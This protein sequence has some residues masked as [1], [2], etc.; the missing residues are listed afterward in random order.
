MDNKTNF[1]L[2]A[3]FA[4]NMAWALV[5]RLAAWKLGYSELAVVLT[6]LA[7]G[8]VIGWQHGLVVVNESKPDGENK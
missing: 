5:V 8:A 3:L 1:R 2:G 6:S 4:K 7:G